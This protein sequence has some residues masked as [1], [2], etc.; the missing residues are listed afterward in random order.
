MSSVPDVPGRLGSFFG[1]R[2]T[3]ASAILDL[4]ALV[5]VFYFRTRIIV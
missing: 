3:S 5:K 2:A 4:D 1:G